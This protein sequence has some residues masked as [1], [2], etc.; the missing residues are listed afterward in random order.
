MFIVQDNLYG[1]SIVIGV[2]KNKLDAENLVS[3]L[4]SKRISIS[5]VL[6]GK[7][8]KFKFVHHIDEQCTEKNIMWIHPATTEDQDNFTHKG[9]HHSG[10]VIAP[11]FPEALEKINEYWQSHFSS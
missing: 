7:L 11:S 8:F 2:Y 10:E 6:N 1:E 4:K 3:Q 5:E 9:I